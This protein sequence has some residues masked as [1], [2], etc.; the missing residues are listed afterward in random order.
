MHENLVMA[1]WPAFTSWD[2]AARAGNRE[3]R[4]KEIVVTKVKNGAVIQICAP[5][6]VSE[7][8]EVS[9]KEQ[10]LHIKGTCAKLATTVFCKDFE[11]V[12]EILPNTNIQKVTAKCEAGILTVTLPDIPEKKPIAIKVE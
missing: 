9:L 8:I 3:E 5:G 2:Y 1:S 6:M 10:R 4:D 11:H 7:N 12:F